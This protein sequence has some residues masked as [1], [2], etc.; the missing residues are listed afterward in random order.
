MVLQYL[1]VQLGQSQLSKNSAMSF[2]EFALA[3]SAGVSSLFVRDF[4][5]ARPMDSKALTHSK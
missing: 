3:K 4:K 2:L 1:A 5:G